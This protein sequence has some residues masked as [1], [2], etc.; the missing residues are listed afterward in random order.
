MSVPLLEVKA[1]SKSFTTRSRLL[2]KKV[3]HAVKPVSFTLEAGQTLGFI[4]Q[5]GSG[6]STLAR[7]LAGWSSQLPEKSWS[8][9]NYWL[10]RIIPHAVS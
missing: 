6:K 3:H 10:M 4:G 9:G 5:N 7:M 8:T 1:L 2:F